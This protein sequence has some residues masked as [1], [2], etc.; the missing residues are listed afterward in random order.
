MKAA[1][2]GGGGEVHTTIPASSHT[3]INNC[4]I[5]SDNSEETGCTQLS[6]GYT[7]SMNLYHDKERTTSNND[8][9]CYIEL[10]SCQ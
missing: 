10:A 6:T 3:I 1:S 7:L 8:G 9:Q 5:V 4:I 2:S